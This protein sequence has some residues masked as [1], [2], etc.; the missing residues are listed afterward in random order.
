[1]ILFSNGDSNVAGTE[2]ERPETQSMAAALGKKLGAQVINHAEA[3]ASNDRIYD[4]TLDSLK[5]FY[6]SPNF[7]VIGWTQFS[8]IQWFFDGRFNEI[9]NMGVGKTLPEHAQ[10]RYRYWRQNIA[11]DGRYNHYLTR[12]WHNKIYNLHSLLNHAKIPHVFFNAFDDFAL[13]EQEPKL[14]WHGCFVEPYNDNMLYTK[15]CRQQGYAEITPGWEHYPAEAHEAW[16]EVLYQH[17]VKTYPG[18]ASHAALR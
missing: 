17:I 12:Y 9:N 1:M 15:W 8:R 13:P 16:A 5:S 2:L 10:S 6:N 14:D 3:G 18:L 4:T 11:N 7:V